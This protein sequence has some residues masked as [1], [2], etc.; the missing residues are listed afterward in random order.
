[1]IAIVVPQEDMPF[2]EDGKAVDVVLNS[3]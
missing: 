1:M 3:L 2:T